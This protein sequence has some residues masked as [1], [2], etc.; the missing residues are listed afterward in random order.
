MLVEIVFQ[1]SWT[2]WYFKNGIIVFR[3]RRGLLKGVTHLPVKKLESLFGGSFD[4]FGIPILP[5]IRFHEIDYCVFGFREKFRF[6]AMYLPIMRGAIRICPDKNI[7]S[8]S[9]MLNYVPSIL[10][11]VVCPVAL[12][13]WFP[14]EKAWIASFMLYA[15]FLCIQFFRYSY[16]IARSHFVINAPIERAQQPARV[17]RS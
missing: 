1:T 11:I 6:T 12:E 2:D 15:V 7:I 3:V 13:I 8:Y 5:P 16:I 9:Y 10:F 14:G 17:G 4:I